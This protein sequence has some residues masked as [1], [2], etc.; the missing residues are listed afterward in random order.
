MIKRE[1]R[2]ALDYFHKFDLWLKKWELSGETG[3]SKQT[4]KAARKTSQV[5]LYLCNY[6]LDEKGLEYVL[7]GHISS[8]Y[9]EGQFSWYRQSSGANYNI[10]VMQILQVEKTT[11]ILSLIDSGFKMSDL[12]DIMLNNN[13][14]RDY[15]FISNDFRFL[16]F[17]RIM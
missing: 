14:C 2:S 4:F 9:L 5:L 11:R 12:K 13:D 15:V 8:G 6:F 16:F 1:D 3:I 10:S 17:T 7:L